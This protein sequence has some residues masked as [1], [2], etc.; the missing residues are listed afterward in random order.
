MQTIAT[1]DLARVHGGG[2]DDDVT[3]GYRQPPAEEFRQ[4]LINVDG[5]DPKNSKWHQ[6]VPIEKMIL[7][8]TDQRAMPQLKGALICFDSTP[9]K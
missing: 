3:L 8:I 4:G 1:I 5:G 7:N 6:C 9:K 2:P